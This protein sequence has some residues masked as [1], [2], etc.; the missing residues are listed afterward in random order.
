MWIRDY[1]STIIML[2]SLS[3]ATAGE[4]LG[5]GT[6]NHV[7]IILI[8]FVYSLGVPIMQPFKS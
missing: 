6:V 2:M 4:I 7:I 1:P 3:F 8:W 5:K